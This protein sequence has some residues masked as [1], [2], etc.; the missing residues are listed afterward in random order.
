MSLTLVHA[1]KNYSSWSMRPYLLMKA[2]G[3]PFESAQVWLG[4]PDTD[5][6]IRRHSPSGRV[7]CLIDSD[8]PGPGGPIT[9]WDSLAIVEY[10]AER[11]RQAGVWPA[12]PRD[13]AL[14]PSACAEMHANLMGLRS[15]MPMNIRARFPGQGRTADALADIARVQALWIELRAQKAA[16]SG[17][18][19][20]GAFSAADA[21]FAPVAF[22]FQTY[23]VTLEGPA[24]TY[25][26]ALLAHPALVELQREAA[27]EGHPMAR[28]D[29]LFQAGPVR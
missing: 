27:E 17:P 14:A 24:A 21:F 26:Q 16:Q 13:P 1:N 4:E 22:R 2:L 9:I 10:L 15:A 20:F 3:I 5:A 19:L 7:P 18:F 23:G 8:P 12:Q 29:S 11:F 25:Q 6:Q 28:Y